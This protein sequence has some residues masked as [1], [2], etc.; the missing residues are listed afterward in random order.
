MTPY[1]FSTSHFAAAILNL[2]SCYACDVA[3]GRGVSV[4]ALLGAPDMNS[5]HTALSPDGKFFVYMLCDR[6]QQ[7]VIHKRPH[8]N[9]TPAG[10]PVNRLGR[11]LRSVDTQTAKT[12]QLTGSANAWDPQWSPDGSSL[13]FYSD[14]DGLARVW[15]WTPRDGRFRRI[16]E[17]PVHDAVR[18]G[19]GLHPFWTPDSKTIIV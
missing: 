16:T 6:Q 15:V 13:A 4:E 11:A 17:Q 7:A 14:I 10:T 3:S 9:F 19:D 18:D 5:S 12:R 1:R 2:V 8:E